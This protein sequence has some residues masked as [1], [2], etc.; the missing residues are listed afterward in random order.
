[1]EQKRALARL[2]VERFHGPG[3]AE[4]AEQHFD[5]VHS[6][7]RPPEE[8]EE[9]EVSRGGLPDGVVH[10]PALLADHF[11]VSRSEARRLLG[12]GGVRLD[13]EPLGP[14]EL[15]V[16]AA[17]AR[18]R[19]PAGRPA[20][21]PADPRHRLTARTRLARAGVRPN[22]RLYCRP[23]A[24]PEAAEMFR[25]PLSE[26]QLCCYTPPLPLEKAV[27]EQISSTRRTGE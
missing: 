27:E 20:Q 15:D 11:G 25:P 13:G 4:A 9:V 10:L 6:D 24:S 5:R 2:L 7:H 3:A 21:V 26:A 23:R 22:R 14:G 17:P 19:G 1:M 12:Q 18:R 8:I 16:E